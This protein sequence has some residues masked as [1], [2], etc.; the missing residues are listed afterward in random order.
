MD[1]RDFLK[2]A[3]LGLAGAGLIGSSIQRMLPEHY[4]LSGRQAYNMSGHAAPKLETVRIGL[5]GIGN[6]GAGAVRRLPRIEGAQITGICD[7][8]TDRVQRAN[9]ELN[10]V[11]YTPKLYS[12]RAESWKEMCDSDDVDL[13][14]ICTPWDQH[15]EQ[16]VY[17]ME[18]GKHVAV[19]L[20]AAKTIDE[21]WQLVEVSEKTGK[22]CMMLGNTCYN[23]FEMMVMNMAR[24]GFLGDIVHGEGAYIHDLMDLNF[25]ETYYHDLWRLRENSERNG[26][27]YPPHAI[28]PMSKLMNINCGDKMD[29]LVSVSSKDFMM[30]DR[31]RELA[32]ENDMWKP[33]VGKNYRGNMNT[34]TIKT[35]KG[36]TIMIQHDVTSPR[37]YSR[38]FLV[39][40]TKGTA[41]KWP[42]PGRIS[43][44]H[45]G[46]LGDEALKELE[47]KYTPEIT[48]RVGD[49][50]RQVGGH[51]GMDTIMDWRLV[52]CLRNGL[53]L[54]IDVYD[55][56][57]W[58]AIAPLTEQS[59][60]NRSAS[61][62]IPDFTRGAW[63]TNKPAMDIQLA[64]GGTTKII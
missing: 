43:T 12:G 40:G 13:V 42:T 39:S 57:L 20:P 63:E 27:L 10:G 54:E 4:T 31:A 53:P 51:G 55:A 58:S 21:C 28:G 45:T 19:E 8:E 41:Q 52:D 32:G 2:Q 47:E 17:A 16:S 50:A 15:A 26:L 36:R 34:T 23:F 60:A 6:R 5:I 59:V 14:Y 25:S 7:V 35:H 37:P 62:D 18:H 29:Y 49:M 44:S 3:S 1:R 48:K 38:I 64:R 61:V 22:H 9:S 46:W 56:A 30:A 33:F 11:A 24:Q